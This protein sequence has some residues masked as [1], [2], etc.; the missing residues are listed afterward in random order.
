[1][2]LIVDIVNLASPESSCM[3]RRLVTRSPCESG[4]GG[5][6]HAVSA[7]PGRPAAGLQRPRGPRTA[8]HRR[9]V[10][11]STTASACILYCMHF[12]KTNA[13]IFRCSFVFSSFVP[14]FSVFTAP[15]H[16]MARETFNWDATTWYVD[17]TAIFSSF[18]EHLAQKIWDKGTKK[19]SCT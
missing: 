14:N 2:V 15:L 7:G 11:A 19:Q 17:Y 9:P 12:T 8:V 5:A 16:D 13:D 1:M 6:A 10:S 4:G 18:K 3:Y